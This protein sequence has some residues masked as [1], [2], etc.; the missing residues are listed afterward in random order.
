M[1]KKRGRVR[2]VVDGIV[3]GWN[4]PKTHKIWLKGNGV[5]TELAVQQ[6][7]NEATSAAFGDAFVKG[8]DDKSRELQ[9]TWWKIVLANT[10]LTVVLVASILKVKFQLSLLGLSLDPA[11]VYREI[12]L[13]VSVHL[14][15]ASSLVLIHRNS[16]MSIANGVLM[17]RVPQ[18]A[19]MALIS[20][21]PPGDF[22]GFL[23]GAYAGQ[24]GFLL[25]ISK[26]LALIALLVVGFG[27]MLAGFVL[28]VG[29][30]LIH[31]E[32]MI[33]IWKNPSLPVRVS[34]TIVCYCVFIDVLTATAV[35]FF[36]IVP[37]R[38]VDVRKG[39]QVMEEENRLQD[40]TPG[41]S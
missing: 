29:S 40:Q 12:I 7:A 34:K 38:Y 26:Y 21:K 22:L 14:A 23:I 25:G 1:E 31:V 11:S 24:S 15:L 10:A 17:T 9:S 18:G 20:R 8:I 13:F 19:S 2:Q 41:R 3:M 5:L 39:L 37:L 28:A 6:T 35:L 30:M 27:G 33:D 16:L 36:D 32:I 4:A